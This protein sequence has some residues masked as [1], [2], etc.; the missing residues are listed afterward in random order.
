MEFIELRGRNEL[1]VVVGPFG[2]VMTEPD[3]KKKAISTKYALDTVNYGPF[4]VKEVHE[5]A[6]NLVHETL[7]KDLMVKF[8]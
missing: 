6:D 5:V 1:F 2:T 3:S 4:A 8:R 7:P